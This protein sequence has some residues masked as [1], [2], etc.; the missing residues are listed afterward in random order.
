MG[1]WNYNQ[2][3]PGYTWTNS[4]ENAAQQPEYYHQ[5]QG[6]NVPQQYVGFQDFLSQYQQSNSYQTYSNNGYQ[7][8]QQ[9][10][11]YPRNPVDVRH[12]QYQQQQNSETRPSK[13]H[14]NSSTSAS[15]SRVPFE[16]I[17]D[18]HH[19]GE[20]HVD[21]TTDQVASSSRHESHRPRRH[22]NHS[23]TASGK[24]VASKSK[25]MAT[26]VE[27]VPQG[28]RTD[29]KT[30]HNSKISIPNGSSE[31][32]EP[33]NRKDDKFNSPSRTNNQPRPK[34][35]PI[36]SNDSNKNTNWRRRDNNEEP[37]HSNASTPVSEDHQFDG[38]YGGESNYAQNSSSSSSRYKKEAYQNSKPK[39]NNSESNITESNKNYN[40]GRAAKT[41][42]LTGNQ[43]QSAE[44]GNGK[45]PQRKQQ[46]YSSNETF[47]Q[48]NNHRR[49]DQYVNKENFQESDDYGN[50]SSKHKNKAPASAKNMNRK[51]SEVTKD[52]DGASVSQRERLMEQLDKGVLE[53][54]VC[55]ERIRQIDS[56]WSC[57][58]C[59]HVLHLKC[60]SKWA[61]SSIA[62]GVWRCPACQNN[63][64]IVPTDYKCFCGK[65]NNPDWKRGGDSAHTCGDI[66]GRLP[67]SCLRHPCTL[68]CHAGPCPQCD[69]VVQKKCECGATSQSMRCSHNQPLLCETICK[70]TLNCQVHTCDDKCHAGSCQP[71][72]VTI[73]QQCYCSKT[74]KR[75]LS[76]DADSVGV[77]NYSCCGVCD[78]KLTC[79]NHNCTS[80]CHSGPCDECHLLPENIK[81]CPCGQTLLTSEQ[82]RNSCL[83]PVPLCDKICSKVF[84]CG[85][86]ED[87]HKCKSSC[88]HG[89]CPP[90]PDKTLVSCRCGHMNKNL[91]CVEL[92]NEKDNVKCGRKCSKKQSCGRH[93]CKTLCCIDTEHR[94]MLPCNRSLTCGLHRC[95]D[96]CHNGH[97]DPCWRT[98][99]DELRCRC[100]EAV[101]YPPIPCGTRPPACTQPCPVSRPC[102][103]PPL[104]V[105]HPAPTVCPPCTVLTTRYC[106]GRHKMRKTI[107]C[108]QEEF[109]C[110][111]PC[112]KELYCSKHKC[113]EICHKGNCP[114]TCSQRC[115]VERPGCGHPCGG[116]CGHANPCPIVTPCRRPVRVT[117]SCG[118][119]T[120][121]KPCAEHMRDLQRLQANA[122]MLAGAMGKPIDIKELIAKGNTTTT[123]ECDDECQI[124]ERNRRLAIG[125][126]I[127]NPDLSAKLTP[128]YSDFLK[129]FAVRD[130]GFSNKIHEKL[131]ELVLLAQKSKQKTRSHS[132]QPMNHQKRQFVHEMCEHF[133]CDSVA[134]D[135]EPYRNIVATAYREKSWLPALS[136]MEII[137]RDKGQRRVPGPIV[138]VSATNNSTGQQQKP[139]GG[140]WATLSTNYGT[141]TTL[142]LSRS[143]ST[144]TASEPS[145]SQDPPKP[146]IDYFDAPPED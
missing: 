75:T 8:Q 97:C 112:G 111:L 99:F 145:T 41:Y 95:E 110:G 102:S 141:S 15:N 10:P 90:C 122:G 115:E 108:H 142:E 128:R 63:N 73:D 62:E 107:P 42:N 9:F 69:A 44:N 85:P 96:T 74:E 17:P 64:S 1:E 68:L 66:C 91:K 82:R 34:N 76:C 14:E 13:K 116:S 118:R 16:P 67:P 25:L 27:F 126:Q 140:A 98:S 12:Q 114:T 31:S 101:R 4:R 133:G 23:E 113:I 136:L 89:N 48:K 134:Y 29:T 57:G 119:R 104:H 120:T 109:S 94:C 18:Q 92:E 77:S 127:R 11:Q 5:Q 54:L 60:I 47:R 84:N 46:S 146:R 38:N 59:F 125:L 28:S 72:K 35:N 51:D 135:T 123:L 79:G 71:C 55:C 93:R 121:T 143:S 103:H 87:R 100:G 19:Q 88:H 22:V 30:F 53:C 86:L 80:I 21:N 3:P 65:Q 81:K 131:S 70:K 6:N 33:F 132:F 124:E 7:N 61:R 137:R 40:N 45:Y 52:I 129:Q 36:A 106:H 50:G 20:I 105:C 56:V 78:K 32:R 130:E 39:Y 117:C 139:G 2:Y 49:N 144:V 43:R 83:D 26:A 24:N 138:T 37:S 58:N